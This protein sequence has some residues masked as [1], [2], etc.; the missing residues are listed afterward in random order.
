[1]LTSAQF[2]ALAGVSARRVQALARAG[3]IGR[4]HG[5]DWIFTRADLAKIAC[6]K[7]GRPKKRRTK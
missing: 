7:P 1:M 4:K 5:R 6:R 2:A 3:R